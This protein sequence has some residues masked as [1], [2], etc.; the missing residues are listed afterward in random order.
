MVIAF[1]KKLLLHSFFQRIGPK[2]LLGRDTPLYWAEGKFCKRKKKH[3]Y[4][5]PTPEWWKAKRVR[6]KNTLNWHS[7]FHHIK[8][9]ICSWHSLLSLGRFSQFRHGDEE[10]WRINQINSQ[11]GKFR[12]RP[13]SSISIPSFSLLHHHTPI[14]PRKASMTWLDM[15]MVCLFFAH[16]YRHNN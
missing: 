16:L 8:S 10:R 14:I 13:F 2:L 7:Y 9:A 6:K 15:F 3:T 4:E 5:P 1:F 12:L 11:F